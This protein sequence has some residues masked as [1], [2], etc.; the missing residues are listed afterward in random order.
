MKQVTEKLVLSLSFLVFVF[1][2]KCGQPNSQDV[3][4]K[5]P[6]GF[7]AETVV[8]SLGKNR[9]IAVNSNGDIYVKLDQ[10]KEGKGIFVLRN[11]NGK[12]VTVNSFGNYTGTGV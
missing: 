1:T 7:K 3:V 4:I 10:L 5:L 6:T 12:Y 11:V 9:H 2:L 8:E